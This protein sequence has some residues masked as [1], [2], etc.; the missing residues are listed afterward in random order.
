MERKLTGRPA[1][2]GLYAGP[3][4]VLSALSKDR[5][6]PKGDPLDEQA[7]LRAAVAASLDEVSALVRAREGEAQRIMGIQEALLGDEALIEATLAA[8]TRA[9]QRTSPGASPWHTRSPAIKGPTT[10]TSGPARLT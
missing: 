8:I 10:N 2:P 9:R 5:Y 6:A 3:A 7:A 1:S 4:A